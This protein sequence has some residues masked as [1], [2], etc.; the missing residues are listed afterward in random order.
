MEKMIERGDI[1]LT[2]QGDKIL[3]AGPEVI[4]N[5]TNFF[6][7]GKT[8]FCSNLQKTIFILSKFR[9]LLKILCF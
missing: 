6:H 9:Y 2:P 4:S 5:R 7:C 8:D 3:S 1:F